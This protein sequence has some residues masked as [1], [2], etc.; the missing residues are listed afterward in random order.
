MVAQK[1]VH[2]SGVVARVAKTLAEQPRIYR[3]NQGKIPQLVRKALFLRLI[4]E[5]FSRRIRK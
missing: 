5:R 4:K 2:K 1:A 3:A